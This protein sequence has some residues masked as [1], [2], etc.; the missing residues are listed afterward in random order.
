MSAPDIESRGVDQQ[1]GTGVLSR[2]R[3]RIADRTLRTD[4]WWLSPL[5]TVLGL[6]FFVIYS[7]IRAFWGSAY[8]VPEYNYLTPFYSP[9]LSTACEP[10]SSHF[11]TLF[12]FPWFI[13]YAALSLPFLLLFRL[14]CYYY[15]KAYYRSVWFSPPACAVAEPHSKYTGETRF[16]LIMQ[17][18]HRYFFYAAALVV[19]INTYDAI[20]AFSGENGFGIGL[21]NLILLANVI[22]LWA[23]TFSCHSCRH[24]AGGR[25]KNFSKHPVRYWFWTQ[26]SKLNT[27]HMQYAWI[28]LFMLMFTDFYV[29]LVASGTIADLRIIN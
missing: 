23:Y 4:R 9:C 5:L 1:T 6:A 10:G 14:T 8:Y 2:T 7:T 13:P 16:P 19:L 25:L 27:R 3:A 18:L 15:R 12:D 20:A 22:L 28:T 11:G 26:V 29:M 24:V 17:N 21:G